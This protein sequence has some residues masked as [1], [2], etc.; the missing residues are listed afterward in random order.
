MAYN[1]ISDINVLIYFLE[2]EKLILKTDLKQVKNEFQFF[3]DK[4]NN[5]FSLVEFICV[6]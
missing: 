4:I 3:K 6:D 1:V 5:I 2:N